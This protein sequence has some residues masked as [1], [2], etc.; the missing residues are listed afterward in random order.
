MAPMRS[1]PDGSA[2]GIH[3]AFGFCCQ[4]QNFR[5]VGQKRLPRRTDSQPSAL[6]QKQRNAQLR[7]QRLDPR[8]DVRRH[9]MQLLGGTG[10]A[11]DIGN[12]LEHANLRQL[13]TSPKVNILAHYK[14]VVVND[15]ASDTRRIRPLVLD[16]EATPRPSPAQN[17]P[18][19]GLCHRLLGLFANRHSHRLA[20]LRPR[21]LALL[22]FLMAS[23]F[24]AVVAAFKGIRLPNLRDLPLLFALGFFAVSLHHVALNIGQQRVSAGASSVLAQST[25]LFSTLLARFVFKDPVSVWRWGCIVAGIGRRGDCGGRR[26]R[27]GQHRCPRLADPAGGGVLECLLCLA[28]ASNPALRR[29]DAGVL[30]GVVGHGVAADLSARSGGIRS[31]AHRLLCSWRCWRWGCFPVRWPIWPGRLC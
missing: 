3:C 6:P 13:H 5:G 12:R 24:M 18:G 10:D 19:D 26:S 8:R 31:S 14:S 7:F 22:R 23:A 29:P 11:A 9:A 27:A 16:H 28:K 17:H 15:Q 21:H 2:D 1:G 30:H 20:G 4:R 25:P